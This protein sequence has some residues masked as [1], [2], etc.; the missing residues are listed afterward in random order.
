MGERVPAEVFSPGEYLS[1][2]LEAR[3][4]SQTDLAEILGRP[5]PVVNQIIKGK[6]SITPEIAKELGAALGTSA[7]LW[8]NLEAAYRLHHYEEPTPTRIARHARLREKFPVSEMVRRR[9]IEPSDDPA[10]LEGQVLRF[11]G[12]SQIEETPRLAHAAK[13]TGYP[14]TINGAQRAWLFRVKQLAQAIPVKPYSEQALREAIPRM[15]TLLRVPEGVQQVP[16]ILAECGVRF[17]IVEHVASSKIDGVCF[18]LDQKPLAPVIGMSLRLDK[19]DNFWFVLRH[20]IEHI[21]RGHG[22]E[23][24]IVDMDAD[25]AAIEPGPATSEEERLAN[26]AGA[27]FCVPENEMANFILRHNPLFSEE[28]ILN[29]AQRLQVHPGIVVGQLQRRTGRWKLFR[30]YL[31]KVRH[32]IAPV[33][34]ADGYGQVIPLKP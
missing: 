28:K 18:W 25:V 34:M 26:V 29:F 27:D 16:G 19:I 14:G 6:R 17:V 32:L 15:R 24:A 4:W 30:P 5:A 20:E 10:V 1:D 23:E 2:E 21:L 8:L 11:F 31:A 3:G 9:W 12:I 33:A 22:R 13:R 7:M